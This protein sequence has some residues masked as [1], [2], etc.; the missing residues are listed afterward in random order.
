MLPKNENFNRE[1]WI[2][3]EMVERE[4]ADSTPQTMRWASF[5]FG[6]VFYPNMKFR[7]SRVPNS[8]DFVFSVDSHD[9]VL[10]AEPGTPDHAMLEELKAENAKLAQTITDDWNKADLPTEHNYMRRKIQL[11][12]AAAENPSNKT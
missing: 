2:M 5:R 11:A 4:P 6:N 1:K 8:D 9:A 3:G 10:Q 7:I 12:K